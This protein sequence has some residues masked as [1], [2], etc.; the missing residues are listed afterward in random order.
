MKIPKME[1][2]RSNWVIFKDRF[3]YAAAAASL[4]SH[5]DGTEALP[6]PVTYPD[7][8]TDEQKGEIKEYQLELF[9]WKQEE[10]IVKQAIASLIPDSLFLEVRRK[11]TAMEMWEA[12]KSQR[13]KKSHMVTVDM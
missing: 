2:D 12:V 11:E 3:F 1:A 6:S 5:I 4:I 7:L 10:A 9:R 8:L 13:E